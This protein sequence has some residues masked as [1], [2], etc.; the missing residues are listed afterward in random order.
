MRHWLA[1]LQACAFG[2]PTGPL[3]FTGFAHEGKILNVSL[4]GESEILFATVLRHPVERIVS[5]YRFEVCPELELNALPWCAKL[6]AHRRLCFFPCR[7]A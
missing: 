6:T 3:A 5:D 2:G 7:P 4:L 1:F